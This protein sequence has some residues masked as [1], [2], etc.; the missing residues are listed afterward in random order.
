MPV[1]PFPIHLRFESTWC[2][3]YSRAAS[4]R[5]KRGGRAAAGR[6]GGQAA[7]VSGA[8]YSVVPQCLDRKLSKPMLI[9][10]G[11]CAAILKGGSTHSRSAEGIGSLERGPLRKAESR[12]LRKAD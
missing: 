1:R 10:V 5:A 7:P 12:S 2:P 11:S 8:G 3:N 6:F 4:L 9:W